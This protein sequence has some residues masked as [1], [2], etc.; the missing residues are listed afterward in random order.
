MASVGTE[1][2]Y[3]VYDIHKFRNCSRKAQDG[4][5]FCKQHQAATPDSKTA[6]WWRVKL[7]YNTEEIEPI[8]VLSETE[9]KLTTLYRRSDGSVRKQLVSKVTKDDQL[10]PSREEAKVFQIRILSNRV[11][12]DKMRLE[13]SEQ[14]LA[15]ALATP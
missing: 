5:E 9:H 8:E 12:S 13:Q 3:R 10:F 14:L 7:H 11:K 4:S 6:T 15:K 1:C 2:K